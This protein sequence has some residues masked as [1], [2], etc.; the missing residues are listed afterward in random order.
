LTVAA[1]A[2]LPGDIAHSLP[3]AHLQYGTRA[4]VQGF[5]TSTNIIPTGAAA[6][7]LN[8]AHNRKDLT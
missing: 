8:A 1:D 6:L 4:C 3:A 7:I 5:E 2:A